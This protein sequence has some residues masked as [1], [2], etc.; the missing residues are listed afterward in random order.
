MFHLL[1]VHGSGD[2]VSV[3]GLVVCHSWVRRLCGS[4]LLLAANQSI[5]LRTQ[6]GISR[7]ALHFTA[8]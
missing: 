6:A 1:R 5:A 2:D 3:A 4:T 7:Q 8:R